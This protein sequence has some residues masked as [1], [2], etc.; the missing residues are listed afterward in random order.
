MKT[1]AELIHTN[2]KN[3]T[4]LWETAG[5]AFDSYSK[6]PVFEYCEINGSEWPNR[7]WLHQPIT[8]ETIDLIKQ[9]IGATTTPIT[10]PV[11]DIYNENESVILENNDFSFIFEQVGM[12]LK[13]SHLFDV[14]SDVEI[15]RVSNPTEAMLWS[16]LFQKSFGYVISSETVNKTLGKIEYYIAYSNSLPVGTAL[17]HKTDSVMGVHAI[18]I[19]PEMR[20]RGY[21]DQIMKLLI[22]NIIKNGYEYI[23]L[24][25]S[26][27]GKNL[28][29]KLGFEEQFLIKNYRLVQQ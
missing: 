14:K 19:P 5:V 4:S 22:N 27:M 23:T 18:G 1:T 9:K 16:E 25:A 6:T 10:L 11:W 13:P 21:A 20:R 7:V 29:L 26:N 3:L 2:V 12:S 17:L 24:Q 28:Y 8:Q 15:V